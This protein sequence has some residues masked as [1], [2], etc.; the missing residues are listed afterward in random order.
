MASEDVPGPDLWDCDRRA[1]IGQSVISALC[2]QCFR[3]TVAMRGVGMT[4]QTERLNTTSEYEQALLSIVR[5]L[6]ME[7]IVQ[8]LDFA[9]YVQS[10]TLED[11]GFSD[12]DAPE[13]EIQADEMRWDAQFL[14]TQEGL[15]KMADRVLADIRAGHTMPMVF[16]KDGEIAPR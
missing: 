12:D 11:F 15:K 16:T 10:Q 9:R 6:P 7:R 1:E 14:A 4:T 13:E 5:T 2:S 3:A 8:I